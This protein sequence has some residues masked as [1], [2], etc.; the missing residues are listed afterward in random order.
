MSSYGAPVNAE[1]S[2]ARRA[3]Q[4]HEAPDRE[5]LERSDWAVSDLADL[6]MR[7][8]S[9][10]FQANLSAARLLKV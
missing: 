8:A 10:F 7:R 1:T 4:D 2:G 9:R 5:V 3:G 6:F